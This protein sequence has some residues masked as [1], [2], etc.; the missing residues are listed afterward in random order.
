MIAQMSSAKTEE[1]LLPACHALER[2]IV[3]GHYLI[4]Q[5]Y[6][7]SH[8]MVYDAWR[9]VVPPQIPAYAPGETWVINNWWARLPPLTA[10]TAKP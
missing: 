2:I 10:E 3:S 1:Q 8:R 5:Y 6:A 4:P 9:L 7:G